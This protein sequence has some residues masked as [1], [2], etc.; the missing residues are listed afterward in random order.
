MGKFVNKR[1]YE[2]FVQGL[3]GPFKSLNGEIYEAQSETLNIFGCAIYIV[4][5]EVQVQSDII[6]KIM[7]EL[8]EKFQDMYDEYMDEHGSGM[9]NTTVR[10]RTLMFTGGL[11]TNN[12]LIGINLNDSM[13]TVLPH[14]KLQWTKEV[15]T[16][17]DLM[18][19]SKDT[20]V[21]QLM[22]L[23]ETTLV[24]INRGL[25]QLQSQKN[26]PHNLQ[27][28]LDFIEEGTIKMEDFE[29]Y[30]KLPENIRIKF[31]SD[32]KNHNKIT[33]V[34]DFNYKPIYVEYPLPPEMG[35]PMRDTLVELVSHKIKHILKS[36]DLI[37]INF[38]SNS[39]NF[40]RAL[41]IINFKWTG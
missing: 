7:V 16:V 14:E 15:H 12:N 8:S 6:S 37:P 25:K 27:V 32:P 13:N 39:T 10:I 23:D 11:Q 5:R 9:G 34:V 19:Y 29:V 4:I 40:E 18:E 3:K 31:E 35:K 26:V 21:L 2:R 30:Y 22:E 17:K 33:G 20:G 1:D 24:K 38:S 28:H 41:F 36:N